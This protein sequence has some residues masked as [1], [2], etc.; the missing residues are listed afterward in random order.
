MNAVAASLCSLALLLWPARMQDADIAMRPLPWWNKQSP[1]RP[2]LLA[3]VS[4]GVFECGCLVVFGPVAAVI[5]VPVAASLAF[6][7]HRSLTEQANQVNIPAQSAALLIEL[8]AALVT[9]G[10]T[11]THALSLVASAVDVHGGDQA[12]LAAVTPLRTVARLLELGT[13]PVVAW[14][15]LGQV[16]RYAALAGAA[17]R[18][19]RTG[20][21]LASVLQA[22]AER[23]RASAETELLA[24][25]N[26][27]GVWCLLPLGLCYLPAFV[28]LSVVPMIVATFGQVGNTTFGLT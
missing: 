3:L 19:S 8:V 14:Q 24:R 20:A 28:C 7:M 27:A 26:R 21:R 12:L 4:A 13:E 9:S 5:A 16:E 17:S 22:H 15:E 6:L 25:V 18:A 11:P 1:S 10:A 2:F 23:L